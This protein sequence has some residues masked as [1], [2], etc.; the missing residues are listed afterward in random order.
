MRRSIP[1]ILLLGAFIEFAHAF[2]GIPGL[3]CG[4]EN[5][6]DVL[7]VGREASRDEI[8]K[9]YRELARVWH[10]DRFANK[11][12]K[13][14]AAATEKFRQIATAYEIL[15]EDESRKD[16]N[17]MLDDPEQYYRHYYRYYRRVYTKVPVH[18]VIIG[19]ITVLSAVQYCFMHSRYKMA[20]DQ[21]VTVPK[22]RF[23]AQD[24]AR[25]KGLL[26]ISDK[27]NARD[28]KEVKRNRHKSKDEL[29]EQEEAIIRQ[30]VEENMDIRG[31]VAKPDIKNILWVQIFYWPVTLYNYIR[32][33]IRWVY[34]FDFKGEPYGEEE[35]VYLISKNLGVSEE[36]LQMNEDVDSLL[37]QELWIKEKFTAW[38]KRKDEEMRERLAEKP[39]YKRY[40]RYLKKGGPG[41]ITFLDD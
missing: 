28:K 22:Y 25:Q 20:I 5:C 15:K 16:F 21:I 6:Y 13:E 10:P 19:L 7:A 33:Y 23:M 8:I 4:L 38:K 11:D 39:G 24:L 37:R 26:P 12:E 30:I 32:W 35:K 2:K 3:Y 1:L 9:K 29:K 18:W 31:G 40:R 41:Q 27:R 36:Q 34:L 17:D 14:R